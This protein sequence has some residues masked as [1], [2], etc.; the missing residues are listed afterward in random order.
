MKD[1]VYS[2]EGKKVL[3]IGNS[4][5]YTGGCVSSDNFG[6]ADEGYFFRLASSLGERPSV[7]NCT[8]GG[9]SL[10]R[11]KGIVAGRSLYERI[12]SEHP[13]F[14]GNAEGAPMDEFYAQ[15]CVILQQSGD[16]IAETYDDCKLIMALFPPTT[17]FAYFVTTHDIHA[18]HHTNVEA[19][20]R[21]RDS[22]GGA[23][24][25]VGH[26]VED[27]CYKQAI[28]EG[29][30]VDYTKNTFIYCKEGDFHHPNRLTGYLTAVCTYC[31]LTG[32]SADGADHS[33]VTPT[34]MENYT[35]GTTNHAEIIA[36][37]CEMN[38]L[39]KLAFDYTQRYN[40]R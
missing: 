29:S 15:D 4:F 17:R 22:D 5:T 25:P 32:R 36:S 8:W 21:L 28:P 18:N 11:K 26:L 7:T 3:F 31:A 40:K 38:R 24:I 27:L 2:L 10:H 19:A 23:Y 13:F 1:T 37:V 9:A 6:T 12:K 20:E 34:G 35:L 14:Y 33:F 30:D 39:K 16:T